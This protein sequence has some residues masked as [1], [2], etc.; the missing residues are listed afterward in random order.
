M[1]KIEKFLKNLSSKNRQAV[2]SILIKVLSGELQGLDVKKL[3]GHKNLFRVRLGDMRI[4]FFQEEEE[5]FNI[6][7]IGRRGDSK[8]NK[9]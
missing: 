4:V 3:K 8:Y 1:N 7:F 2:K 6:I 9:F 5:E